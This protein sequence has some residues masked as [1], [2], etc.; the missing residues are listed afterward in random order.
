MIK[1]SED[2]SLEKLLISDSKKILELVNENRGVLYYLDW[3]DDVRCIESAREYIS[4]RIQRTSLRAECYKVILNNQIIGVF[5]IKYIC[6]R[7]SE[8]EIGY[9]L[10]KSAQGFGVVSKAIASIKEYLRDRKIKTIKI[11]CLNKNE[12]GIAVISKAGGVMIGSIKDYRVI[13]GMS[14]DLNLYE[15]K[16]Y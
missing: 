12:P 4:K 14:F 10:A 3:V 8:A 16:L 7:R 2:I 11:S 13:D 9:W 15:V 1:V 6:H 5:N